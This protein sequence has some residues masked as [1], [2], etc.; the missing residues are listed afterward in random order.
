MA[1]KD[2]VILIIAKAFSKQK[3]TLEETEI[4]K[5]FTISTLVAE[6]GLSD[7]QALEVI[8]WCVLSCASLGNKREVLEENVF[9][10]LNRFR[11]NSVE[12][13]FKE[14]MH[15]KS[16]S[17]VVFNF[18][19]DV[20]ILNKI[21]FREKGL[22]D[23]RDEKKDHPPESDWNI[24]RMENI[25]RKLFTLQKEFEKF[26]V[27]SA[28]IS[29]SLE[30]SELNQKAASMSINA[31]LNT[32]SKDAYYKEDLTTMVRPLMRSIKKYYKIS[33]KQLQD[34]AGRF[35][36]FIEQILKPLVEEL[37]KYKNAVKY[38]TV[39]LDRDANRPKRIPEIN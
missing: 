20:S 26:G 30:F 34:L 7:V 8:N 17:L 24:Q 6:Y 11:K 23:Y 27:K 19:R 2:D 31:K 13:I 29:E 25:A 4:S 32:M 22:K 12:K 37:N 16:N 10:Y 5:D 1:K 35:A 14:L 3:F 15:P 28:R 36:I 18:L 38:G 21:I 33:N 39:S 9:K